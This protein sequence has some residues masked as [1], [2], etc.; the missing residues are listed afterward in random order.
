MPGYITRE[1]DKIAQPAFRVLLYCDGSLNDPAN[2]AGV[3][4]LFDLFLEHYGAEA[5]W[6]AIADEARPMRP[7]PLDAAGIADARHW[8]NT[9]DKSFPATCRIVGPI[10]EESGNVTVPAFRVD[11]YRVMFLDMSVPA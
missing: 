4:R 10:S 11:E 9:P 8:L 1:S 6:L 2:A 5:A 3:T 7:K